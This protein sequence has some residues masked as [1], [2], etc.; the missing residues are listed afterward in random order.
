MSDIFDPPE[1]P[2]EKRHKCSNCEETKYA[3]EFNTPDNLDMICNDC[4]K[5]DFY[6]KVLIE[7][8]PI[9]SDK[10]DIKD[11]ILEDAKNGNLNIVEFSTE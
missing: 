11:Y 4:R 8:I 5:D 7:N 6:V 2:E 10:Q 1:P 3:E 9:D